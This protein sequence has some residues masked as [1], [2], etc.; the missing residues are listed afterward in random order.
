MRTRAVITTFVVVVAVLLAG[1]AGAA[2]ASEPALDLPE[3]PGGWVLRIRTSGGITGHGVGDIAI[4]SDGQ[5]QCLGQRA[6]CRSALAGE[7]MRAMLDQVGRASAATWSMLPPSTICMDCVTTQ[8]VLTRRNAD[9][10]WTTLRA[11]WDPTTRAKL[12]DD[13][14]RLH[15]MT[16]SLRR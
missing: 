4:A 12:P 3:V 14:T 16:V 5:L 6:P 7:G 2:Q 10:T 11:S 9:G 1:P 13:V 8:L 15:D